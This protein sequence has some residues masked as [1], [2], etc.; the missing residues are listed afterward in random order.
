MDMPLIPDVISHIRLNENGEVSAF[1]S[2]EEHSRGVANLASGFAS[3]FNMGKWGYVLGLLHDKGKEKRQF[4]EYIRDVNGIPGHWDYTSA[5][6]A[7]AYVG[8]IL[9]NNIYGKAYENFLSNQI[10]SHHSGLHD[11]S[12]MGNI[13][14]NEIPG[15]IGQMVGDIS[16]DSFPFEFSQLPGMKWMFPEVHH[17]S[18]MLF[19]CLVDADYLDTESFMDDTSAKM[20]MNQIQMDDLLPLLEQYISELERNS[21]DSEINN[22]RRLVRN[23][24]IEMSDTDRGFYSLTVPTGGGKTLSSLT[25]AIKH[26]IRNGMRRIIIAIP[27]TSIIIQTASILKQIFGEEAVLEHHSNFDPNSIRNNALRHKAKLATENWDYPIIVTTNVQL[28]ESMF[29]NK[30]S[31]CRKL[32]NLANSV[33]ILDEVQTLPTD[34]L[35]PI[36]DSLKTYHKIFGVSF[37]FTT[38]SQSVLSGLIEGCNPKAS[39]KG[40]DRIQEII[41]REYSLHEKLRRVKLEFDKSGSTYEEIAERLLKHNKVLC[42]VNTRKDAHEIFERL[43]KEGITVHLSR[44]M[45]PKHISRTIEK[46]KR[47]LKE[48]EENVVRVVA[49]QLVEAGVDIDFPVVYRQEAGLDSIIQA[50]GRCNREGKQKK[51]VTYVFSLNEEHNLH[52]SIKDANNARLNIVNAKDWFSP[53][54]MTEYFIQLYCRKESFDKKDIKTL[55][56]KPSEMC[57]A[58]ASKMF[59]LIEDEGKSVVVNVD[60]SMDLIEQLKITGITYSLVKQLSQ[61]SVTLHERDF[62]KLRNFGAIEEIIEGIYVITDRAQYDENTGLKLDNHWMNEILT[63]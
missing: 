10:V 23:R 8:G 30:P 33:V 4:Q 61:Y 41:P 44:M 57:F 37:L 25:W 7:H 1:Q 3:V 48:K 28:F 22:I 11:Y 36:V 49:T 24:C 12:E 18:R 27:Y 50:A 13:M 63:I 16:L 60:N 32:H 38:A 58:E 52:G 14:N 46:L 26:A 39:F 55:L 45:C 34:F 5:G 17:V 2:N 6:K 35:Q 31:C 54:T 42:I 15:E 9:A 53:E 40:I 43:P 59:R 19:S 51:A 62:Q 29:S 47:V 21:I 20:R 56:Y